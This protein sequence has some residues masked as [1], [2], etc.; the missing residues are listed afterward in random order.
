[1]LVAPS[2]PFPARL[3]TRAYSSACALASA[4]D[5]SSRTRFIAAAFAA[6]F[7]SF[8]SLVS[9]AHKLGEPRARNEAVAGAKRAAR[10]VSSGGAD[11]RKARVSFGGAG[12]SKARVSFGG[13][14]TRKADADNA[15]SAQ[16]ARMSS[17]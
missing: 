16:I 14:G 9:A 7:A 17:K 11:T 13:A 3:I 1:V 6:F 2:T 5:R 10:R 15:S 12:K 4:L 8:S